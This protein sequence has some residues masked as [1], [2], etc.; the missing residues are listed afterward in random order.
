MRAFR[1][2][3]L[4]VLAVAAVLAFQAFRLRRGGNQINAR[5]GEIRI[6]SGPDI[7]GDPLR[8]DVFRQIARRVNPAVVNIYTT[9]TRSRNPLGDLFG[10][11]ANRF[12]EENPESR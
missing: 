12:S 6:S 10:N 11:S 2:F 7:S 3:L 8:E 1:F 5:T 4:I 9:Q